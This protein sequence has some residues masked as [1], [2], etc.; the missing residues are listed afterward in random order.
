MHQQHPVLQRLVG[1][2]ILVLDTTYCNP[3]YCFPSQ[4][5][6]LKFTL[7]AVAAESFNPRALFLFGTYTIGKSYLSGTWK[8]WSRNWAF[9][10]RVCW[11][12]DVMKPTSLGLR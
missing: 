10:G 8:A 5:D 2:S 11:E 7:E 12:Y 3:T 4:R 6:T 9:L 1:R